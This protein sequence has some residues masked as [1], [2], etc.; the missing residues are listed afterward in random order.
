MTS[1]HRLTSS[2]ENQT[3]AG[4]STL[5]EETI[6]FLFVTAPLLHCERWYCDRSRIHDRGTQGEEGVNDATTTMKARNDV[7]KPKRR[8]GRRFTL[9]EAMK[10][11][12]HHE[13]S[14]RGHGR[15]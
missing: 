4:R 13:T 1:V 15:G 12:K 6:Y 8:R 7:P 14:I 9:K 10:T 11:I 2:R 3:F 5:Q